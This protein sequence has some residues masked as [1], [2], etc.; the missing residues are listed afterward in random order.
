MRA[1]G[2][3]DAARPHM[4]QPLARFAWLRR[5]VIGDLFKE[6][7]LIMVVVADGC[8]A[9]EPPQI[10]K[11]VE[12]RDHAGEPVADRFVSNLAASREQ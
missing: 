2:E 11:G 1:C 3:H 9:D 12:P 8:R 7:E 4:P 10:G 5:S 6:S